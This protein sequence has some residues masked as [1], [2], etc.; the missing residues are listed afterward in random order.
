MVEVANALL[1][2]SRRERISEETYRQAVSS[3]FELALTIQPLEQY[4]ELALKMAVGLPDDAAYLALA[5]SRNVKLVTG[6]R[7]LF[8][9]AGAHLPRIVWIEEWQRE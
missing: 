8:N 6:D 1:V 3:L 9:A 7:R 5:A 2:A 4:W